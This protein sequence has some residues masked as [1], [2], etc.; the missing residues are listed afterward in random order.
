[1]DA[2]TQPTGSPSYTPSCSDCTEIEVQNQIPSI[3]GTASNLTGVR[4]FKIAMSAGEWSTYIASAWAKLVACYPLGQ[5]WAAGLPLLR[6]VGHNVRFLSKDAAYGIVNYASQ[7]DSDI[8]YSYEIGASTCETTDDTSDTSLGTDPDGNQITATIHQPVLTF[9]YTRTESKYGY[10]DRD[11]R[12]PW[13]PARFAWGEEADAV[14]SQRN[15]VYSRTGKTNNTSF[16]GASSGTWLFLGA[17]VA[18]QAAG[19]WDEERFRVAYRF[20]YRPYRARGWLFVDPYDGTTAQVYERAGFSSDS[21]MQ[22]TWPG[23]TTNL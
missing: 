20:A 7:T 19:N 14:N 5:Y 13:N 18:R 11:T 15:R 10:Y 2:S 3:G 4:H 12:R 16:L 17:N 21:D 22:L 8:E 23:G 6:V 1:M 9:T